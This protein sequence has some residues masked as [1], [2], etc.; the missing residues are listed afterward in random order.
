MLLLMRRDM[1]LLLDDGWGDLV[2]PGATPC[3]P[4]H[5]VIG[6]AGETFRKFFVKGRRGPRHAATPRTKHASERRRDG[7]GGAPRHPLPPFARPVSPRGP[8]RAGPAP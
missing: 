2:V 6:R 5:S 1:R 7:G 4:S 3:R 8:S